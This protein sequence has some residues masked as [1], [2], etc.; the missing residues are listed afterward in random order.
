[1]PVL[2]GGIGTNQILMS[3]IQFQNLLS[4]CN[5]VCIVWKSELVNWLNGPFYQIHHLFLFNIVMMRW[6]DHHDDLE[7]DGIFIQFATLFKFS[8]QKS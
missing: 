7:P 3:F 1:M 8:A 2:T 4:S 5:R 6:T